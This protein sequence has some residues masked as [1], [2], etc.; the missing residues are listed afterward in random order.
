MSKKVLCLCMVAVLAVG[1]AIPT[2]ADNC[3]T[4]TN[5]TNV[6]LNLVGN[7]G[8]SLYTRRL[9]LYRTTSVGEDQRFTRVDINV[10][11]RMGTY[12]TK[13]SGQGYA[14]N[15]SNGTY[16]NGY[17]AFMWPVNYAAG[18]INQ[19]SVFNQPSSSYPLRLMYHDL[20]LAYTSS[21]TGATV[22]FSESGSSWAM[23][24]V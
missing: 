23:R 9:S 5:A 20:G 22:Y 13:T 16:S 4:P 7:T 6:Y 10:G 14:I 11:G 24:A 21:N 12:W 17:V 15:K 1:L 8:S 19:D 3:F 2:F 18:E